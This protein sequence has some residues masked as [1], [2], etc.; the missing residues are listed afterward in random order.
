MPG[1]LSSGHFA[2]RFQL[3]LELAER[4]E[5]LGDGR[6]AGIFHRQVTELALSA[7]DR[8]VCQRSPDFLIA[9]DH[10]SSRVRMVSFTR[11]IVRARGPVIVPSMPRNSS[12]RVV[13]LA[14]VVT[15]AMLPAQVGALSQTNSDGADLVLA[16]MAL[17]RGDCR[18]GTDRY[19]KA[20]LASS[21]ARVSERANKVASDCQQVAAGARAAKRWQSS[22]PRAPVP[23]PRSRWRRCVSINP[24]KRR[25]QSCERRRWAATTRSSSSWARPAMPAVPPSR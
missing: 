14:L 20:A 22:S 25:R 10:F 18:G 24:M 19:V 2:R 1:S 17:S 5:L 13:L 9:V 23:R 16:D 4:A 7:N 6:Q 15:W 8:G 21:D 12:I 3:A 11:T